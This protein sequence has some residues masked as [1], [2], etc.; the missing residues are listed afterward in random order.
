MVTVFKSLFVVVCASCLISQAFA[1]NVQQSR[2][3]ESFD[4]ITLPDSGDSTDRFGFPSLMLSYD[5]AKN[6]LVTKNVG[7]S[8]RTNILIESFS[9]LSIGLHQVLSSRWALTIDTALNNAELPSSK[10]SSQLSDLNLKLRYRFKETNKSKYSVH[11]TGRVPIGEETLYLSDE[12]FGYGLK[13][14]YE[15]SLGDS[16]NMTALVGYLYSEEAEF[17]DLDYVNRLQT[18]LGFNYKITKRFHFN[19]EWSRDWTLPFNSNL[20][21]N[22]LLFSFKYHPSKSF[23]MFL[24]AGTGSFN[25]EDSSDYRLFTGVKYRPGLRSPA[26]HVN[27]NV[28]KDSLKRPAKPLIDEDSSQADAISNIRHGNMTYKSSNVFFK[29]GATSLNADVVAKLKQIAQFLKSKK[30][31]YIY[32]VGH[33]DAVGREES[34]LRLSAYRSDAVYKFLSSL[35]VPSSQMT[36]TAEGEKEPFDSVYR[37]GTSSRYNRRT[38]ILMFYSPQSGGEM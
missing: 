3:S 30:S 17:L 9:S 12:S 25:K 35:G 34:N 31:Y 36:K 5:F 19:S 8:S 4:Y 24:G 22:E 21:P 7:N 28:H 2:F 16:I 37:D 33:A 29:V 27:S 38:Q 11:F 26:G 10:E 23:L 14:Q 20:N 1:V 18:S 13:L 15:R 32:I 6:P